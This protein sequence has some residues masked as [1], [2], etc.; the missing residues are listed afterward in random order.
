MSSPFGCVASGMPIKSTTPVANVHV[1]VVVL[2]DYYN[3]ASSLQFNT[4][5]F[6]IFS[7]TPFTSSQCNKMCIREYL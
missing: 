5:L 2:Q 4:A 6:N 7:A 1:R 3:V